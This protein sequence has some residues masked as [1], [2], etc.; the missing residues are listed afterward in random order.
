MA[1][2]NAVAQ[3]FS[4]YYYQTFD[5]NRNSLGPL[6]RPT[7]MLTFEGAQTVG[8]AAIVE[9]LSSLPLDGLRHNISTQDAQPVNDGI[10]INVTGQ[11]LASGESNP[12]FFCQTFHLKPDGGSFYIQ[13]DIFRLVYGL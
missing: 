9:K 11:L 6:Y 3:Q 10:L 7:S 13:N 12:Q 4:S 5:A 1:D 2:I 8:D